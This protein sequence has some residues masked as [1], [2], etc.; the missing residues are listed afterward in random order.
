MGPVIAIS[1]LFIF[2]LCQQGEMIHRRISVFLLLFFKMKD[3]LDQLEIDNNH[4]NLYI[5]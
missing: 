4:I 1:S 5:I 3:F 2:F